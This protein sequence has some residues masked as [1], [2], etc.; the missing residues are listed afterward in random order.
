MKQLQ[1]ILKNLKQSWKTSNNL[2]KPQRILDN[3]KES[4]TTSGSFEQLRTT[5]DNLEGSQITSENACQPRKPLANK[6]H[7][8]AKS[9]EQVAPFEHPLTNFASLVKPPTN[10]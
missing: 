5:S 1:T 4:W 3:L 10:N 8:E 2:G 6:K 7:Q 9:L